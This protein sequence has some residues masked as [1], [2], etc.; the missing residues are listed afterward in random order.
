M[1]NLTAMKK[2]RS[3]II[4][5]IYTRYG[6]DVKLKCIH[7]HTK[8]YMFIDDARFGQMSDMPRNHEIMIDL[9]YDCHYP[10]EN[11]FDKLYLTLKENEI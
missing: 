6:D 5:A 9:G 3:H 4:G 2:V 7:Y 8:G 11:L 1:I 10:K